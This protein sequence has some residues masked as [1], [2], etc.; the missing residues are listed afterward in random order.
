MRYSLYYD[1]IDDE[2]YVT[3]EG[4]APGSD[5]V[6]LREFYI[7]ERKKSGLS[8]GMLEV[9][10]GLTHGVLTY[11]EEPP[12]HVKKAKSAGLRSILIALRELGIGFW[13]IHE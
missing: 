8:V 12:A 10:A 11:I 5:G 2:W 7:E 3:P 4:I 9:R 1:L 6:P 13:L